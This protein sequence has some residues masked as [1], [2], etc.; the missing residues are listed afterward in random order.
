V[1]TWLVSRGWK[2]DRRRRF[3]LGEVCHGRNATYLKNRTQ[4]SCHWLVCEPTRWQQLD[5]VWFLRYGLCDEHQKPDTQLNCFLTYATRMRHGFWD[6][7]CTFR[8]MAGRGFEMHCT[9]STMQ[10]TVAKYMHGMIGLTAAIHVHWYTKLYYTDSTH[11][12]RSCSTRA[13]LIYSVTCYIPVQSF[14]SRQWRIQIAKFAYS[15]AMTINCRVK[16]GKIDLFTLIHRS[17]VPK[18]IKM[19]QCRWT[20]WQPQ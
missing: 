20:R 15:V 11:C 3:P 4:S 1:A 5:G 14:T 12:N 2:V 7:Q 16:I 8:T 10:Y 6:M 13:S 9:L 17:R 19:T 18:R